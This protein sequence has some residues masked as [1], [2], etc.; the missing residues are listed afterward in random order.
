MTERNYQN[1]QHVYWYKPGHYV[2]GPVHRLTPAVSEIITIGF[3]PSADKIVWNVSQDPRQRH[4]FVSIPSVLTH[5]KDSAGNI[6]NVTEKPPALAAFLCNMFCQK[7]STILVVGTGAGG[8]VKGMLEAGF[9]VVGV[10][11]DEKQ[12]NQLFS[13]MNSWIARIEKEKED[14]EKPVQKQ[15]KV[16]AA[17][18][19]PEDAAVDAPKPSETTHVDPS[20][21]EGYCF[22]CDEEETEDNPLDECISCRKENH[23]HGCMTEYP[24]NHVMGAGLV[25]KACDA[26]LLGGP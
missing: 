9:N 19:E 18:E 22:Y 23:M 24:E 3:L 26:G 17:S 11:N 7:G 16:K 15:K 2:E 25:C 5:S 8:C 4:N 6:I 10:E 1:L 14:A 12:Y 21:Q 20:A 13:E